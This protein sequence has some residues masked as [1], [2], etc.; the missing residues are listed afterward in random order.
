[1]RGWVTQKQSRLRSGTRVPLLFLVLQQVG[2]PI[3]RHASA[4]HHLQGGVPTGVVHAAQRRV[5]AEGG[6]RRLR[7]RVPHVGLPCWRWAGGKKS[8]KDNAFLPLI[9]ENA[10][11]HVKRSQEGPDVMIRPV[12]ESRGKERQS[13]SWFILQRFE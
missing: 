1:M 4:V 3:A 8:E 13:V 11:G 7:L 2:R 12:L 10:I 5:P 6:H 9:V